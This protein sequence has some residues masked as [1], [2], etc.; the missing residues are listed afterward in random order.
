M[1][2]NGI[3]FQV[4]TWLVECQN[5]NEFLLKVTKRFWEVEL[6]KSLPLEKKALQ[7]PWGLE[8]D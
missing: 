1:L 5:S 7:Y 2:P 3:P 6:S 4:R 8:V